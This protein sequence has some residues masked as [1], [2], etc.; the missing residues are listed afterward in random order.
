VLS[1]SLRCAREPRCVVFQ[2][3][4]F[5]ALASVAVPV[6]SHADQET[7][8]EFRIPLT[9][10]GYDRLLGSLEFD[11]EKPRVDL[12]LDILDPRSGDLVLRQWRSGGKLR[13]LS[14][15]DK[16]KWQVSY[17]SSQQNLDVSGFK[18]RISERVK[19]EVTSKK[20]P[21]LAGLDRQGAAILAILGRGS[22]SEGND[23]RGALVEL[24]AS[25][26][27][28]ARLMVPLPVPAEGLPGCVLPLARVSKD[29]FKKS[30]RIENTELEI[31]L[32]RSTFLDADGN[33]VNTWEIEAE[34]A[35]PVVGDEGGLAR[36]LV[37]FLEER[38]LRVDDTTEQNDK[39]DYS[40]WALRRYEEQDPGTLDCTGF[41]KQGSRNVEE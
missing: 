10:K 9:E 7:E 8:V 40:A 37:S 32:G 24:T 30:V 13:I 26:A 34:R 36:A 6:A 29:R 23:L 35:G 15:P 22:S 5:L 31:Q 41:G 12:Y 38:G 28:K 20:E 25:I 11:E 2:F 17:K 19:N 39:S 18:M 4:A 14:Q 33:P 1:L 21:G 3:A 16:A 27:G